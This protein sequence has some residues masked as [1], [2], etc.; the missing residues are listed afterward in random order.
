VG[1]GLAEHVVVHVGVRIHVH[2][3]ELAVTT[4]LCAQD[5][6]R[7]RVIAAHGQGLCARGQHASKC[8]SMMATDFSRL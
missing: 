5:R 1:D 6:Q 7:D 8:S 2:D 4:R 3:G